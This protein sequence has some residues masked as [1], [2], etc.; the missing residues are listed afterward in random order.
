M[1]IKKNE[2]YAFNRDC[3][4]KDLLLHDYVFD[5]NTHLEKNQ[6]M[7]T[8]ILLN[9]AICHDSEVVTLEIRFIFFKIN[10]SI[11]IGW[12]LNPLQ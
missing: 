5:N 11:L 4:M 10:R 8:R 9:V 1:R 2:K 12:L 6:Q 7:V 3:S